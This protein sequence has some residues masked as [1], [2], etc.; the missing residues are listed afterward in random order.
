MNLL[1]KFV[2]DNINLTII[3]S[4]FRSLRYEMKITS[5]NMKGGQ[6]NGA[7]QHSINK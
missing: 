6:Q 2:F 4:F 3:V 5:E 1:N 7:V